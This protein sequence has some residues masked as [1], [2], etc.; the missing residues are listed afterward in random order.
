MVVLLLLINHCLLLFPLFVGF[1]V[2]SLFCNA[3]LSSY[4]NTYLAEYR[5]LVALTTLI[6]TASSFFSQFWDL[7]P[8]RL[9]KLAW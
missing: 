3:V 1:N 9:G 8:F 6:V 7:G 4:A 5:E 2:R